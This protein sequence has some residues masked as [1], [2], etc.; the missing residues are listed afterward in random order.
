MKLFKNVSIPWQRSP[1]QCGSRA[2]GSRIAT[3]RGPAPRRRTSP[4]PHRVRSTIDRDRTSPV[5]RPR[6]GPRR[7]AIR[8]ES[9]RSR[10][11]SRTNP[12]ARTSGDRQVPVDNSSGLMTRA[13]VD[14]IDPRRVSQ[15]SL[16]WP[17]SLALEPMLLADGFLYFPDRIQMISIVSESHR[18]CSI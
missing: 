12:R 4:R 15:A 2:P 11:P 8:G 9:P 3:D 1:S 14:V 7:T 17:T 10:C 5:Y 13:S 16:S 18:D 6:C